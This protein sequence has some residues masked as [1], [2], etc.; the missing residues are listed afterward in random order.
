MKHWLRCLGIV[1][2]CMCLVCGC[3]PAPQLPH[4][5]ASIREYAG[6]TI[7]L[8]EGELPVLRQGPVPAF[9]PE[10]LQNVVLVMDVTYESRVSGDIRG[11][12]ARCLETAG[13]LTAQLLPLENVQLGV[14]AYGY[15][16]GPGEPYSFRQTELPAPAAPYIHLLSGLEEEG[17]DIAQALHTAL[18]TYARRSPHG[19]ALLAATDLLEA[20]GTPEG[21]AC[22]ILISDGVPTTSYGDEADDAC[23]EAAVSAAVRNR[24]PIYTIELHMD[25][26]YEYTEQELSDASS[27]EYPHAMLTQTARDSGAE[28]IGA[29]GPEAGTWMIDLANLDETAC[30][31]QITR[32]VAQILGG[33]VTD[34]CFD[35]EGLLEIPCEVTS[36]TCEY[37]VCFLGSGPMNAQVFFGDTLM[38]D[39]PRVCMV[40][41]DGFLAVRLLCPNPGS[42]TVEGWGEAGQPVTVRTRKLV[43]PEIRVE[44]SD[45]DGQLRTDDAGRYPIVKKDDSLLASATFWYGDKTLVRDHD[46]A[47]FQVLLELDACTQDNMISPYKELLPEEDQPMDEPTSG[48]SWLKSFR[49]TGSELLPEENTGVYRLRASLRWEGAETPSFRSPWIEIET[50]DSLFTACTADVIDLGTVPVFSRV[51]IPL[52]TLGRNPDSDQLQFSVYS[53]DAAGQSFKLT[54]AD[55]DASVRIS[56]NLDEISLLTSG[57]VGEHRLQLNVEDPG[58]EKP[59]CFEL[60]MTVVNTPAVCRELLPV[61]LMWD[62]AAEGH[63]EH[64]YRTMHWED[65]E[66]A[67]VV[68]EILDQTNTDAAVCSVIGDS[69]G[70]SGSLQIAAGKP[71]WTTVTLRVSDGALRQEHGEP[72]PLSEEETVRV[73]VM[74]AQLRQMLPVIFALALALLILRWARL[75][76][77]DDWTLEIG[78]SGWPGDQRRRYVVQIPVSSRSNG[79]SLDKL[80][81]SALGPDVDLVP[82]A[83]G[84][85]EVRGISSENLNILRRAREKLS[86]HAAYTKLRLYGQR[87]PFYLL[88]VGPLPPEDSGLTITVNGEEPPPTATA[89]NSLELKITAADGTAELVLRLTRSSKQQK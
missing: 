17:A 3:A 10:K 57:Y 6:E 77:R 75:R 5:P 50:E 78:A 23:R 74:P 9:D 39:D 7:F 48:N 59:D 45:R 31:G 72:I 81:E 27:W 83:N 63:P 58:K 1:L 34:K 8:D 61:I 2:V 70:P 40:R 37:Q 80:M 15:D 68:L 66:G 19:Q 32:A 14:I 85:Y 71:G 12:S 47:S 44:L 55:A 25:D 86:K 53:E 76:T 54:D 20:A 46:D 69:S 60:S 38:E 88:C 73:L 22:V 41:G 13:A 87:L 49:L 24:W 62:R 84:E 65:P 67:P 43:A 16:E 33:T 29:A 4:I 82:T 26:Y 36:M 18:D 35:P 21:R 79:L 52:S 64:T 89:R 42:W 11:A 51:T 28:R 56:S 30:V